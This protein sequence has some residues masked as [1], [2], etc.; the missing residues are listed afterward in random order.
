MIDVHAPHE[1]IHGY[2]DFLLHLLTI[3]VGLLIALGLEGCVERWHNHELRL[4]A[5][6]SIRQEVRD[7]SDEMKQLHGFITEEEL[8]LGKV[9]QY[10]HAR[11]AG[12]KFNVAGLQLGFSIGSLSESSW[13]T[14]AATGALNQMDYSQVQTYAALYQLQERFDGLQDQTFSDFQVLQSY[15]VGGFNP[16]TFPAA[17]AARAEVDVKHA[18]AHLAVMDDIGAALGRHYDEVLTGKKN[19]KLSLDEKK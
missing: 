9:L 1:R 14:A 13:R 4:Q 16:E 17:D 18:L 8:R 3:T 7:N 5:E 19:S 15:V 10:L 2:K 11:E 12:E 6:A